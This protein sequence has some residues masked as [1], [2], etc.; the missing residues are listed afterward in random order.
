[1]IYLRELNHGILILIKPM[2][3]LIAHFVKKKIPFVWE[4]IDQ[5]NSVLFSWRYGRKLEQVMA[6]LK[7]SRE[8]KGG[9]QVVAEPM[10]EVPASEMVSFFDNQPESAYTYFRPHGFDAESITKLQRNKS[11]IAYVFRD[12]DNQ[13]IIGYFFL[14]SFFMGKAYRGRMVDSN[15]QSKGL[16]TLGNQLMAEVGFG[17]GLRI[18][19]S[20]SR[21]NIASYRSSMAASDMKV[22]KELENDE[23]LLEVI[24]N[25]SSS[26]S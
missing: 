9:I 10:M 18:Y 14:R 23:V 26:S 1:M 25:N 7:L 12:A 3:Y 13:K 2:L 16:A 19:E 22:M 4:I 15:Y 6:G 20:V 21:K 5:I 8:S 24:K 17:I 11:F